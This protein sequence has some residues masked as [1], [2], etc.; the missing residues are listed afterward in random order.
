MELFLRDEGIKDIYILGLTT[1]YCVKYSVMDALALGFNVYVIVD[2]CRAVNL[3][4]DDTKNALN[5]MKEEGAH[6]IHS[7]NLHDSL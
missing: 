2:G 3:K 7:Q 4:P 6:L 5:E 1:E